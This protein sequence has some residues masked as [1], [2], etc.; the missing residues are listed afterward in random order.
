MRDE[1]AGAKPPDGQTPAQPRGNLRGAVLWS[2]GILLALALAWFI[3]AVA[4]PCYQTAETIRVHAENG[5]DHQE[6]VGALGGPEHTLAKVRIY[7]AL[8]RKLA[9]RK[10]YAAE[11]LAFC[12]QPAIPTLTQALR[13]GDELLRFCS[14]RAL[15]RMGPEA[16]PAVPA[17]MVALDDPSEDV[18]RCAIGAMWRI[19]PEAAPAVPAL[20]RKLQ[21]G[22]WQIR[23]DAAKALGHIG[24]R[25]RGAIPALEVLLKDQ[26]PNVAYEVREAA[27]QALK[28]VRGEEPPK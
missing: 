25:A 6:A 16:A 15:A 28:Q 14:V 27:S 23:R 10:A 24:P 26:Q 13:D 19:G 18:R 1:A 3:G 8:P 2:A 22:N 9:P 21:D 5:M 20:V 4:V 12:G 17:L 7:L 11:M